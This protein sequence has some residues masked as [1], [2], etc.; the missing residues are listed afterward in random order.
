MIPHSDDAMVRRAFEET[1]A[2]EDLRNRDYPIER[3]THCDCAFCKCKEGCHGCP[4]HVGPGP[5]GRVC[6]DCTELHAGGMTSYLRGLYTQAME[7]LAEEIGARDPARM[8]EL[9][10]RAAWGD[11]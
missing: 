2:W 1:V 11:R 4:N 8:D 10:T 9:E 7:P 6:R 5:T 3:Y